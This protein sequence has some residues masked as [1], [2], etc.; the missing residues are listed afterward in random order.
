MLL[1]SWGISFLSHAREEQQCSLLLRCVA[2]RRVMSHPLSRSAYATAAGRCCCG[3]EVFR[4][5]GPCFCRRCAIGGFQELPMAGPVDGGSGSSAQFPR[6]AVPFSQTDVLT[7]TPPGSEAPPRPE[8]KTCLPVQQRHLSGARSEQATGACSAPAS[9]G[10][11]L[12]R[13][14]RARQGRGSCW[15]TPDGLSRFLVYFF[16]AL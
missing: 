3:D 14:A 9:H 7:F 12:E 8:W 15:P 5:R 1:A 10:S 6:E 4:N 16:D 11:G 13:A 2:A